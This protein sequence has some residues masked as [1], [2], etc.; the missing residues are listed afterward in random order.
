[1]HNL[2]RGQEQ[3]GQL[4]PTAPLPIWFLQ[5][6]PAAGS[7]WGGVARAGCPD[8]LVLPGTRRGTESRWVGVNLFLPVGALAGKPQAVLVTRVSVLGLSVALI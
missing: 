8:T 4:Q 6:L 7:G 1:M 5:L 3:G 2:G